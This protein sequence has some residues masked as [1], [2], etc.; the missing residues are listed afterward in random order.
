[1]RLSRFKI[2]I[3][4]LVFLAFISQSF[5]AVNIPCAG[6][7]NHAAPAMTEGDMNMA[8]ADHA[9]P[10]DFDANVV[11]D[12][13]NQEQC[14]QADCISATVAVVGAQLPFPVLFSQ[15]FNSEYSVS[16]LIAEISSL[17]R[18]PISR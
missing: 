16:Y 11:A 8:Y 9:Q 14:S 1:M 7:D 17:F 13:C 3:A 2:Y 5:A 6:M 10:G 4:M 12:C 18:P 15:T